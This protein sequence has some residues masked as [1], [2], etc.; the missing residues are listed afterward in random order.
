MS[1]NRLSIALLCAPKLSNSP[2]GSGT[3][4]SGRCRFCL[5]IA[6]FGIFSGTLRM[7]S[8]S[9]EKQMS[10]VGISEIAWNARRIIVVRAT[11]P[12]V[13]ICGSPLGP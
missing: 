4:V 3:L 8:R 2:N 7:P 5:S 1:R 10:R 12:K 13:P 9:S 6:W 11:S